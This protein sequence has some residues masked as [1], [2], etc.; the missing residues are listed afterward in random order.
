M[1]SKKIKIYSN[2]HSVSHSPTSDKI[3]REWIWRKNPYEKECYIEVEVDHFRHEMRNSVGF[4][5]LFEDDATLFIK[6]EALIKEWDLEEIQEYILD[7]DALKHL[8]FEGSLSELEDFVMYAPQSMIDSI[9]V[10]CT[11]N[12]LTDR[13]K[14]KLIRDYT[15]KDL[16]EYYTDL[17]A[18]G[19]TIEEV[20]KP[21][22][23]QPR[24][25]REIK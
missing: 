20:N 13:K 19:K 7:V 2:E 25:K 22:A 24:V 9:E 1:A 8:V 4:R 12:E 15:G 18:E 11:E 21:K 23:R 17:E 3:G 6:D 10:I 16:E 14:I 5:R